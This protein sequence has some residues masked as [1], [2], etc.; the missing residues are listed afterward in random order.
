MIREDQGP[1]KQSSL[2]RAVSA[3]Y[4]AV[5]HQIIDQVIRSIL[6]GPNATGGIGDRLRRTVRHAS[7]LKASKSSLN[8]PQ[9][10]SEAVKQMRSDGTSQPDFDP[11]VVSVS[12][13]VSD[14]QNER[15]RAD[16]DL[17]SAFTRR[18]ARRLVSDARTTVEEIRNL[19]VTKADPMI[20]LLMCLLGDSITKNQ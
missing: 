17:S 6:S 7:V 19:N 4:Y 14:L 9:N 15:H 20:Y 12:Q 1:P 18:E 11:L 5:F 2:R 16:Y 13:T 3:A 8:S 10:A